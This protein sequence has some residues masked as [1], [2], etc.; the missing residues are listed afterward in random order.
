M[1]LAAH[2]IDS[3]VNTP[4]VLTSARRQS[5]GNRARSRM[6]IKETFKKCLQLI[7]TNSLARKLR[8]EVFCDVFRQKM[9]YLWRFRRCVNVAKNEFLYEHCGSAIS[10]V[11]NKTVCSGPLNIVHSTHTRVSYSQQ[12]AKVLIETSAF[13]KK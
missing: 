10:T 7:R 2:P 12:K 5:S 6:P 13:A 1:Y 3:T 11:V 8:S 9:S 4:T